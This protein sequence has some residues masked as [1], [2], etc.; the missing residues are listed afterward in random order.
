MSSVPL[1]AS[2]K[3]CRND[4]L[5]VARGDAVLRYANRVGKKVD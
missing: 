4:K 3:V 2:N 5:E 1:I